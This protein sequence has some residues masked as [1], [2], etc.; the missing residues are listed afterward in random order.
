MEHSL[1]IFNALNLE[2]LLNKISSLFIYKSE[3][4]F[5]FETV[6]AIPSLSATAGKDVDF[7]GTILI[8]DI[9]GNL[10]QSFSSRSLGTRNEI[11]PKGEISREAP[12][13]YDIDWYNCTESFGCIYSHTVSGGCVYT[14]GGGSYGGTISRYSYASVNPPYHGGGGGSGGGGTTTITFNMNNVYGSIG[15]KP[16]KEFSNKCDGV[17]Y[18]WNTYPNNEVQG[19]I[20]AD[21]KLLMTHVLSLN[22]GAFSGIY[23]HT[24][25][26]TNSITA[27]YFYPVSQGA[28]LQS[29]T[30]IVNNGQYYFIPIAASVHTHTPCRLDGTD[31]VSHN[32]GEDDTQFAKTYPTLK[33]WVI[34]CSAIARFDGVS[35]N[36]FEGFRVNYQVCV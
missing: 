27:Y 26:S 6:T 33:H 32:V 21:G 3:N 24:D 20:T 22:G 14:A 11:K 29:Y 4:E 19:F 8:Q 9:K 5:V 10:K 7:V 35:P 30:G 31:G 2:S 1:L 28:P 17:N 23:K 13:C 18:M 12:I 25:P 15:T 34:G 36:F 16:L